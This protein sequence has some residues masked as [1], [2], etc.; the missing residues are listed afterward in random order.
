MKI[1]ITLMLLSAMMP[2]MLVA[3]ERDKNLDL[4][5]LPFSQIIDW[6][7]PE[8]RQEYDKILAEKYKIENYSILYFDGEKIIQDPWY[9]NEKFQIIS[10]SLGNIRG[11]ILSFEDITLPIMFY[12]QR[13]D[14]DKPELAYARTDGFEIISD[15]DNKKISLNSFD[16]VSLSWGEKIIG[17]IFYALNEKRGIFKKV[18]QKGYLYCPS[19][20]EMLAF[21]ENH[22]ETLIDK[23]LTSTNNQIVLDANERLR[24]YGEIKLQIIA[25]IKQYGGNNWEKIS[26]DIQKKWPACR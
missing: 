12:K 4:N 18:P 5:K 16:V 10:D 8:Q 20:K 24:Q 11:Y 14:D 21:L 1:L 25:E 7:E 3:D 26:R 6:R 23:S 22:F 9:G 17:G 15:T 2:K 13:C 19:M